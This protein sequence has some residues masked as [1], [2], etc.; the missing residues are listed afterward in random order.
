MERGSLTV[1]AALVIPVILL[2]LIAAIE[3]V[4][5]ISTQLELVS[6]A[7]EGA[8]VAATTPDPAAAVAAARTVIGDSSAVVSVTRPHVVGRQAE[9]VVELRKRLVTPLLGGVSIPLSA[10]AVMRVE[11]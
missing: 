10:R 3:V 5:A 4:A 2:V 8:R 7:R 11:L 6:A 1:E 9:V